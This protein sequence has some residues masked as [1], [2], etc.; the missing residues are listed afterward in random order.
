M[1]LRSFQTIYSE[2]VQEDTSSVSNIEDMQG[3]SNFSLAAYAVRIALECIS[4]ESH[5][6]LASKTRCESG[7]VEMQ[8]LSDKSCE[9]L[10]STHGAVTHA[11]HL[12]P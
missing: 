9:M 6:S 2:N 3:L 4:R 8:T 1:H 12:S 11:V 10:E 5:G 7:L